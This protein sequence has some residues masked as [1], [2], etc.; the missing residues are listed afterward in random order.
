[1]WQKL[2]SDEQDDED[3][4]GASSENEYVGHGEEP[5]GRHEEVGEDTVGVGE[6]DEDVIQN[7]KEEGPPSEVGT[8][9]G[10]LGEVFIPLE[11]ELG[12]IAE[13]ETVELER[14]FVQSGQHIFA[15]KS[16]C[17]VVLI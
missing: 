7:K 11:R 5:V 16:S 13:E 2:G 6:E 8:G 9:E 10:N 1:M 3:E 4:E 12:Q 17:H 14:S 15:K